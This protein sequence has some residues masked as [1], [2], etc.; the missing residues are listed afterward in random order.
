L[1]NIDIIKTIKENYIFLKRNKNII[2]KNN[3]EYEK[4]YDSIFLDSSKLLTVFPYD[5]KLYENIKNKEAIDEIFCNVIRMIPESVKDLNFISE[6]TNTLKITKESFYKEVNFTLTRMNQENEDQ[7]YKDKEEKSGIVFFNGL[8]VPSK[9]K[10]LSK[11][12]IRLSIP[13]NYE[14]IK[15]TINEII[16]SI[17]KEHKVITK[18]TYTEDSFV[19]R[20]T[21]IEKNLRIYERKSFRLIPIRKNQIKINNKKYDLIEISREGLSFASFDN[22]KKD[23]IIKINLNG[24]IISGEIVYSK[25]NKDKFQIGIEI[26]EKDVKSKEYIEYINSEERKVIQYI[27]EA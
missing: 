13:K 18:V 1:E 5:K 22:F 8:S 19:V 9:I 17:N 25:K 20:G 6:L 27:K 2:I 3:E 7:F 21:F 23:V 14:N 26:I 16:F 15:S 10:V 24:I 4:L 11:N 12:P